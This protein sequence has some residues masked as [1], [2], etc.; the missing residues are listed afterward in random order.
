MARKA[1]KH[2]RS[3]RWTLTRN[4]AAIVAV[5]TLVISAAGSALFYRSATAQNVTIRINAV[6]NIAANI[7]SEL[8][9]LEFSAALLATNSQLQENLRRDIPV[10]E[11]DLAINDPQFAEI[12]AQEMMKIY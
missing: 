4:V 7:A 5:L 3:I 12:V 9:Q 1:Q 8:S 2:I 6:K 11:C 10:I